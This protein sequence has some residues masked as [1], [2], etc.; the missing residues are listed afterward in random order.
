MCI[1]RP[2]TQVSAS[3]HFWADAHG[4]RDTEGELEGQGRG[5][6]ERLAKPKYQSLENVMS[7]YILQHKC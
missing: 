7:S 1:C 3:V 4:W 2:T 5:G 6:E